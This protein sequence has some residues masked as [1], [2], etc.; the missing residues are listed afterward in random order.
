MWLA[1]PAFILDL[2]SSMSVSTSMFVSIDSDATKP[3]PAKMYKR[4]TLR[5]KAAIAKERALV[6]SLTKYS[7]VALAKAHALPVVPSTN[8]GNF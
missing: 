1:F 3:T 8:A 4:K 5:R 2:N 7:Q 6:L